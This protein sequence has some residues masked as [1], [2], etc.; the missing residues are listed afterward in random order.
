LGNLIDRIVFRYVIDFVRWYVT[1]GGR[2]RDWP[3]FNLADAAIVVGISL[4]VLQMIPK[5]QSNKVNLEAETG[6]ED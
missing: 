6:T 3:T 2:Q 1:I 5:K 4:M